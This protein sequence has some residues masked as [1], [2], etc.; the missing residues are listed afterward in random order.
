ME[1]QV[2]QGV[3]EGWERGRCKV[4]EVKT[5]GTEE[6][7]V[8]EENGDVCTSKTLVVLESSV[9]LTLESMRVRVRRALSSS[10]LESVLPCLFNDSM[11]HLSFSLL[12]SSFWP[13]FPTKSVF[14]GRQRS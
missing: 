14:T 12:A 9:F 10:L 8:K 11:P 13:E 4:R 1:A 5:I 3:R 2:R 6:G 7:S